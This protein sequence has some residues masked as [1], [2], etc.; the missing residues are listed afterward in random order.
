MKVDI[1]WSH[2][3]VAKQSPLSSGEL[4]IF[5]R[6]IVARVLKEPEA[7][8][9]VL[10][11]GAKPDSLGLR[12]CDDQEMR[13][14]HRRLRHIDRATDILSFPAAE[15]GEGAWLEGRALGDL[16]VSLETVQRAATRARRS[17]KNELREVLIHGVLHL[18]G[19]DHV[20][21]SRTRADRMRQLQK[22]I[23]RVMK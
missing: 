5:L 7:Q 23:L 22:K 8:A 16:L 21:V 18:F 9:W 14:I 19:W 4:K 11:A 3:S 12:F 13:E 10:K 1:Q 20:G 15:W 2:R 6:A 17:M